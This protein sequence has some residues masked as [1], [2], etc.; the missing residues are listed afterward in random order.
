MTVV[1]LCARK[2]PHFYPIR[3][4]PVCQSVNPSPGVLCSCVAVASLLCCGC[5]RRWYS[6]MKKWL[7]YDRTLNWT[8]LIPMNY[9]TSHHQGPSKSD[10]SSRNVGSQLPAYT[11]WHCGIEWRPQLRSRWN[12]KCRKTIT[13][14]YFIRILK[15]YI[16]IYIYIYADTRH[17]IAFT[18]VSL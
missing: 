11:V 2:S 8:V 18:A 9:I 12:L 5:T 4:K 10:R 17:T 6:H 3:R 1:R 14:I 15:L 7:D 13:S 16:Y